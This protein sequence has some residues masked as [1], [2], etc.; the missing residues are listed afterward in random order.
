MSASSSVV[1]GGAV[2]AIMVL[3]LLGARN[4]WRPI[5][6]RA[7]DKLIRALLVLGAATFLASLIVWVVILRAE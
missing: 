7:A 1:A 5:R 2:I 6:G 4:S 3:A